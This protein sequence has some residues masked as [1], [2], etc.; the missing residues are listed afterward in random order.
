MQRE[1]EATME[2]DEY[3]FR[4]FQ[5]SICGKMLVSDDALDEHERRCRR[6]KEDALREEEVMN[7]EL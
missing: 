5:C 4:W 7:Y 6:E 1:V 3:R 2:E